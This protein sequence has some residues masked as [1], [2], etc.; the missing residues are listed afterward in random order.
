MSERAVSKVTLNGTILID[1]TQ[2][3]VAANN[4]LV[5]KTATGADG[6]KVSGA[7]DVYDGT[8]TPAQN[9]SG[10]VRPDNWPN[11]DAID[12]SEEECIFFTYDSSDRNGIDFAAFR[13][14][15]TG[16][17]TV[18]RGYLEDGTWTVET[19]TSLASGTVF[20]ELL[21]VDRD[22]TVYKM[23][24]T[25]N[26]KHITC[27]SMDKPSTYNGYSTNNPYYAYQPCI[28]RYGNL[29]YVTKYGNGWAYSA[30]G[31]RRVVS[32]TLLSTESLTTMADMFSGCNELENV[33]A[34]WNTSNV[35]SMSGTFSGCNRLCY[36]DVSNWD[37]SQVTTMYSMFAWCKNLKTIDVSK[38]D[39][40]KVTDMRR[41]FYH[42][43]VHYLDV[44]KWDVSSVT[45][46]PEMFMGTAIPNIDVSEWDV[47]HVENMAS[48]FQESRFS[49][50]D[51]SKW[52][53]SSVTS[54]SAMFRSAPSL[55][56]LD[57]SG[58]HTNSLTNLWYAFR[59]SSLTSIDM[60]KLDLSKV[61]NMN[62]MFYGCA[63]LKKIDMT[64]SSLSSVTTSTSMFQA[65]PCIT[66]IR[67]KDLS[68]VQANMFAQCNKVTDFI[69]EGDTLPVLENVNAFSGNSF[70]QGQRI[71][72]KASLVDEAK[73]ATNWS[74]YADY[75][76]AIQE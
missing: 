64:G 16:G 69:F 29:P 49:V 4:L 20:Y 76:E 19:S 35:T 52:D 58:W 36:L 3:T 14:Y 40:S 45:N 13:A 27:V 24:P 67:I 74:T 12:I 41:M 63:L 75:I 66:S 71:R 68:I 55:T 23:M 21:P 62:S 51:V 70:A 54:M 18:E 47:S 7:V 26:E 48:M 43:G 57:V 65:C 59:E 9:K 46:M 28:E 17:Y 31:N 25:D 61:T 1:V 30:W 44:S 73:A 5:G 53:V 72:F 38:W 39:T 11:Y 8:V 37:T 42:C 50:I 33:N 15:T 6:N 60:S 34:N 22:F 32:E 56:H 10:W 2:D